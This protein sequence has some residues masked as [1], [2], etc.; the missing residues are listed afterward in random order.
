MQLRNGY[1]LVLS[2]KSWGFIGGILAANPALRPAALVDHCGVLVFVA[3]DTP[4]EHRLIVF[5][6]GVGCTDGC[7]LGLFVHNGEFIHG[8][9]GGSIVG[10]RF[11]EAV[12][13]ED[14]VLNRRR[15][16][17]SS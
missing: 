5:L 9:R 8:S 7:R 12:L 2:Q 6:P 1:V 10:N 14:H 4:R 3:V 17:K 16:A 15:L 11:E 13:L